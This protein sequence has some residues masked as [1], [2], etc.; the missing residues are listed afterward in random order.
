MNITGK[1][2]IIY[3]VKMNANENFEIERND[4]VTGLRKAY[5]FQDLAIGN[6]DS[7]RKEVVFYSY[8]I[9]P[10]GER[11]KRDRHS[12]TDSDAEFAEFMDSELWG[13]LMNSI[14]TDFLR[15]IENTEILNAP[16]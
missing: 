16:E 1:N 4:A 3:Q 6:V 5:V 11:I 7:K 12:F 8:D 2:E 15:K 9:T 10:T 14:L 13:I